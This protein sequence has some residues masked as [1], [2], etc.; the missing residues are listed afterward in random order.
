MERNRKNKEEPNVNFR[1][2]SK[3]RSLC[4]KCFQSNFQDKELKNC[5]LDFVYSFLEKG[6]GR[7]KERERNSD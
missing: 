3:K 4:S 5:F 2:M 7:E 1:K 6:E